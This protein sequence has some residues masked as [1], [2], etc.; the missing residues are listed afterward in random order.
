MNPDFPYVAQLVLYWLVTMP[1]LTLLHEFGHGVAAL[2]VTRG[3]VQVWLG[4]Y[5]QGQSMRFGRLE[6][7]LQLFSTWVGGCWYSDDHVSPARAASI[8]VGGPVVSIVSFLGCRVFLGLDLGQPDWVSTAISAAGWGAM[9]QFLVTALP[10]RYPNW[11]PGYRGVLSDGAI[12]LRLYRD[13][14]TDAQMRAETR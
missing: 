7:S 1:L 8:L 5:G 3:P 9:V 10:I 13:P 14:T 6:T 12:L 2:L 4:A 11:F